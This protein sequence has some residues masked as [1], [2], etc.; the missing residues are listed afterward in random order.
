MKKTFKFSAQLVSVILSGE[1]TCTWRLWDEKHIQ[2]GDR[3]AFIKRPELVPFAE[4]EITYV[5]EKKMGE[6]TP[7]DEANIG[8]DP[9]PDNYKTYSEYYGR[10]VTARTQVKV[11]RFKVLSVSV[12]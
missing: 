7:D 11:V 3:V 4:A 2:V 1:K 12:V 10:E 5:V 8:H 9:Y 6:I